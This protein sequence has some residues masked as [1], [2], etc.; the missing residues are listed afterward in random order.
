MVGYVSNKLA[1]FDGTNIYYAYHPGLSPVLI[2]LQG[3]GGNWT[4]WKKEI[5]FFQ[6]KNYATLAL[7]FRGHGLSDRISSPNR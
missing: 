6:K 3:I 7:D 2:F 1:S 5:D 4:V